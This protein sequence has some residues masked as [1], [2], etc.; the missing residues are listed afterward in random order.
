VDG[1]AITLKPSAALSLGLVF[2]E[3]TVSAAQHGGLS[4]PAGR[5]SVR[6]APDRSDHNALVILWEEDAGEATAAPAKK[7]F[8]M[9]LI[10]REV[11][12]PLGGTVT[13]DSE[14]QG[15]SVRISIPADPSRY[16]VGSAGEE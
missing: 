14:P 3:L 11:T 1:P 10:Q 5:V 2:H 15:L 12:T 6:W 16:S 9:E 7:N 4:S 13:F 8:G